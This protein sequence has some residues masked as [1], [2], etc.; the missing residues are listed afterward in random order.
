MSGRWIKKKI[1]RSKWGRALARRRWEKEKAEIERKIKDGEI[2]APVDPWPEETPFY[3]ITLR[4]VPTGRIH[5]FRLFRAPKGRRDQFRITQ[6]GKEWKSAIGLTRFLRGLGAAMF[7]ENAEF[8]AT[9]A[10]GDR[11]E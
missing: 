11:K 5:L 2:P 9:E 7:G 6:D 8:R 10:S 1:A 3:E 4:H